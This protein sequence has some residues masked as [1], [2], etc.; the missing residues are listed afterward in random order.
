MEP[1]PA[2][3]KQNRGEPRTGRCFI[4][5]GILFLYYLLFIPIISAK[6]IKELKKMSYFNY[7]LGF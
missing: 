6:E 2:I 1:I 3:V 7:F 4:A 5:G